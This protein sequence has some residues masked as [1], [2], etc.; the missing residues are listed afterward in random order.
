MN[1]VYSIPNKLYY[2]QNFLDLPT[3]K[4]LHYDVFKDKNLKFT[5]MQKHWPDSL[6]KGYVNSPDTCIFSN[7]YPPFAKISEI[8]NNN[9]IY[10]INF[11]IKHFILTSMRENSCINWHDD[12]GHSYGITYYINHSW[13][14]KFGGEFLFKHENQNG[15]IPVVGNSLLIVKSPLNHKVVPVMKSTVP[16]KTVQIFIPKC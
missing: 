3:Y 1:L 9:S 6:L 16:R 14:E 10:K 7:T 11:K 13:N 8:L 5:S 12:N 2:I 4:K 15:C